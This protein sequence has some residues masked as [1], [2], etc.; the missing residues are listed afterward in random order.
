MHREDSERKLE[1]VRDYGEDM[2]VYLAQDSDNNRDIIVVYNQGGYDFT[3]VDAEDLFT[4]LTEYYSVP[5]D[6]SPN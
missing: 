4:A 3:A 1:G 5:K 2:G 6:S